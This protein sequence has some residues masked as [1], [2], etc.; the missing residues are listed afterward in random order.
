MWPFKTAGWTDPPPSYAHDPEKRAFLE[1]VLLKISS[2]PNANWQ[3]KDN[4]EPHV[5]WSEDWDSD[6]GQ[7]S[8]HHEYDFYQAIT[9]GGVVVKICCVRRH[10]HLDYEYI[11]FLDEARTIDMKG[12]SS[13]SQPSGH[14]GITALWHRIHDER[15]LLRAQ[16]SKVEQREQEHQEKLHQSKEAQKR[17][18][19]LDRL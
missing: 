9:Q 18:N 7:H 8:R 11:L 17:G 4:C 10:S 1:T 12:G 3:G 14:E 16:K 6:T 13:W 2:I 5:F 19:F 15:E